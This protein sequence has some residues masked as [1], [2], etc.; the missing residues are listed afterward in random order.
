MNIAFSRGELTAAEQSLV[1]A[2]FSEHARH[3]AAPEYLK[4]RL[5]WVVEGHQDGLVGV[6]TADVLW[7]WLY[8]DE[9][10]VSSGMRGT[11]LGRQLMQCA[12]DFAIREKLEGIWLWTQSWQAEGFYRKLGY[13][14]F[15][16][17]ERFPRGHCRIGFRKTLAL[18]GGEE[19]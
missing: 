19:S 14:E 18:A 16:R 2:G 3:V 10:W 11:G 9:L 15:T 13:I 1:S 17:F 5:K 8:I 7:D 12:E 6:L 4:D